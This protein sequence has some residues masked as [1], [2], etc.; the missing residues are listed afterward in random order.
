MDLTVSMLMTSGGRSNISKS[1]ETSMREATENRDGGRVLYIEGQGSPLGESCVLNG[2][3]VRT[4]RQ[5]SVHGRQ[6][7]AHA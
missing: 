6:E 3:R 7:T 2:D 1:T 5:C 4:E